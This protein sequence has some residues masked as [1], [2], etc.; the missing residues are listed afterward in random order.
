M[1]LG[2]SREAA[3]V[4]D[5]LGPKSRAAMRLFALVASV[6]AITSIVVAMLL[7]IAG[8]LFT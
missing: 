6:V 1:A 5:V 4:E 7:I 3:E 2:V 8:T